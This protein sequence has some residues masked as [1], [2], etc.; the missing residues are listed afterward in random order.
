MRLWAKTGMPVG[1][2]LGGAQSLCL[3]RS[4]CSHDRAGFA[5]RCEGGVLKAGGSGNGWRKGR[6]TGGGGGYDSW[7]PWT[8]ILADYTEIETERP[9]IYEIFKVV[10]R[11]PRPLQR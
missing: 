5:G 11:Q 1:R 2:S 4:P 6:G 7:W 3:D 8:L 9:A 10:I